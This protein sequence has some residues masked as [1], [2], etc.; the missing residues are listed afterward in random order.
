MIL[1]KVILAIVLFIAISGAGPG[2]EFALDL[3]Y[4]GQVAALYP[5]YGDVYSFGELFLPPSV[6]IQPLKAT[7]DAADKSIE[8]I[9]DSGYD[10]LVCA[11]AFATNVDWVVPLTYDY[12][13]V[14]RKIRGMNRSA[15]WRTSIHLGIQAARLELLSVRGRAGA[16]K[17][18]VLMTDGN[19][20][21]ASALAEAEL[22]ADAGI[23]LHTVGLGSNVD[24]VLLDQI[25]ALNGGQALYIDNNTSPAVYGPELE[26]VFQNLASDVGLMLID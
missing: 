23:T 24:Q 15:A 20:S 1:K 14:R 7:K 18:L 22:A 25:A 12:E 17:V 16:D 6:R 11:V 4:D 21:V 5:E 2:V 3:T 10:D 19:S 9:R 8:I 26:E 13:S